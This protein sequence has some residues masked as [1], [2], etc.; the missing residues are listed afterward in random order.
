VAMN[1]NF[2]S[3]QPFDAASKSEAATDAGEAAETVAQEG[4]RAANGGEPFIVMGLAIMDEQASALA[5]LEVVL[6]IRSDLAARVILEQLGVSPLHSA[7]GEQDFGGFPGAAKAFEQKN[8]F[9]KSLL[10]P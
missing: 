10:D 8:G 3:G 4:P 2:L 9:R 5:L 6:Q 7:F 1:L